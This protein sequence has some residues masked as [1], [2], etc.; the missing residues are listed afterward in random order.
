MKTKLQ[1]SLQCVE[2]LHIPSITAPDISTQ[3]V[4]HMV[5]MLQFLNLNL[6]KLHF[7]WSKDLGT[8]YHKAGLFKYLT[9]ATITDTK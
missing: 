4:K 2:Y 7:F 6:L 8:G 3:C 9:F 1:F 5:K